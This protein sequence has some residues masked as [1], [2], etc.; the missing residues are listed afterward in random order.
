M[1]TGLRTIFVSF[2]FAVTLPFGVSWAVSDCSSDYYAG[3]VPRIASA[4]LRNQ[5]FAICFAEFAVVYSGATRTPLWSAEHLTRAQLKSHPARKDAFHSE[6]SLPVDARSETSDYAKSG[7][8]MGHMTPSADEST[9][10][11]Q[12]QSFSLANMVPQTPQLNRV[13]WAHI[14][15]VVRGLAATEG[16]LFVV[17]G[18]ILSSTD[19][20]L[21]GRVRVPAATFK[22]IY[23]PVSQSAAAYVAENDASPTFRIVSIRTLTALIRIDVF[24]KLSDTIKAKAGTLPSP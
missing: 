8:D 15:K 4:E 19:K 2:A 20:S 18:P 9:S 23:D 13:L 10:Q 3:K 22:A 1:R 6:K 12:R 14:E 11:A 16:E 7:Y 21:R 24:P 17:T 5:D